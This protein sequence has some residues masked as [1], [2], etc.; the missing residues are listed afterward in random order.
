MCRSHVT[1]RCMRIACWIPRLQTHTHTNTH[2]HTHTQ[3]LTLRMYNTYCFFTVS[4]VA[5]TYLSVYVIHTLPF[6]L[7]FTLNSYNKLLNTIY[8]VHTSTNAL[9]IK[10]DKVLKFTL[11]IT[12]IC[13]YIFRS[14]TII[15]EPSLEPG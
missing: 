2:T 9:F 15:R 14:M 6:L 1:R 12:L 10:D 4:V 11:K 3:T 8:K 5:Q 13:S 7:P